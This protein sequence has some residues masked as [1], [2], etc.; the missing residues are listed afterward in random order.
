MECFFVEPLGELGVLIPVP[1]QLREYRDSSTTSSVT[2]VPLSKSPMGLATIAELSCQP[3]VPV[4]E[5]FAPPGRTTSSSTTHCTCASMRIVYT[6]CSTLLVISSGSSPCCSTQKTRTRVLFHTLLLRKIVDS[7]SIKPPSCTT[8]QISMK[9]ATRA[10]ASGT[11][12]APFTT[13]TAMLYAATR[14][15][16]LQIMLHL[17][18]PGVHERGHESIAVLGASAPSPAVWISDEMPCSTFSH[19]ITCVNPRTFE[20]S[21]CSRSDCTHLACSSALSA[22]VPVTIE[23]RMHRPRAPFSCDRRP[24]MLGWLIE[25]SLWRILHNS[26]TCGRQFFACGPT[27]SVS[28]SSSDERARW[29]R[30]PRM[31]S[32]H[33]ASTWR[34]WM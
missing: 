3:L 16:I 14:C 33:C 23:P 5:W 17:P 21:R 1:V 12:S 20:R 25:K 24:S 19:M 34:Y 7:S 18:S 9:P 8:H 22:S 27:L 29:K 4:N 13:S 6:K 31:P 10:E 2:A 15:T 26:S 28:S 30:S 11:F 32:P